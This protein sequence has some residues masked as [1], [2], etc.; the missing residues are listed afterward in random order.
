[1]AEGRYRQSQFYGGAASSRGSSNVLAGA[2]AREVLG[3]PLK[4]RTPEE[5]A[6]DRRARFGP[7]IGEGVDLEKSAPQ[8]QPIGQKKIW[9]RISSPS[10]ES[11][12]RAITDLEKENSRFH[13]DM[14]SWTNNRSWV[15]GYENVLTPMSQLSVVFHKTFDN[16]TVDEN[17]PHY[18]KA[19]LHLLLSQTSCFRY[20]G[21]GLWTDY[22]HEIIRRGMEFLQK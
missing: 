18:R 9:D 13:L 11:V 21:Q 16:K 7:A 12:K 19:L 4:P 8:I 14:G 20:W 10:P 2:A 6:A 17:D 22:A 3:E 1:M 15:K 5:R